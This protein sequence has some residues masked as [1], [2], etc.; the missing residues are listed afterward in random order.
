MVAE[1]AAR[2]AREGNPNLRAAARGTVEGDR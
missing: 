1:I 2:L